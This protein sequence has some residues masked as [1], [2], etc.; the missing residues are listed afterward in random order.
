M[1]ELEESAVLDSS[2]GGG[3]VVLREAMVLERQSVDRAKRKERREQNLLQEGSQGGVGSG[4]SAME[5]GAEDPYAYL[6]EGA[7]RSVASS[8][9]RSVHQVR[10]R[11]ADRGRDSPDSMEEEDGKKAEMAYIPFS[12]FARGSSIEGVGCVLFFFSFSHIPSTSC[13]GSC[14]TN[15][16][17]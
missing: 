10:F 5:A 14:S 12:N 17:V 4:L 2:G 1:N 6:S 16:Y 8:S 13:F 15:E 7:D 11:D 3:P 9:G